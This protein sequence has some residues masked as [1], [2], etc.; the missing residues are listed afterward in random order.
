MAISA[1][2]VW[3]CRASG[4]GVSDNNG[5]GYAPITVST[6][7]GTDLVVDASLNTK[8]TSAT[9]NFVL[10]DAGTRIYV[11][12]GTGW[13]PGFYTILST[14]SNAA[15][16]NA[17]PAPTSTT[18]GTW[19]EVGAD[20][21]QQGAPQVSIDDVTPGPVTVSITANVIT[22]TGYTPTNADVG[23]LVHILQGTNCTA[24]WYQITATGAT[25]WTVTGAVNLP[26]SGTTDTS[27]GT[28]P[29]GNMGGALLTQNTLATAMVASNTAWVAGAFTTAAVITFAQTTGG[30]PTSV[31]PYTKVRGYGSVRGDSGHATLQC[32]TNVL[33]N[34]ISATG[35]G[36]LISQVDVDANALGQCGIRTAAAYCVV[37]GCK[38][39]N[40]TTAGGII[41]GG[42]QGLVEK[43]ELTGTTSNSGH[44]IQT[45]N[46]TRIVNNFIHDYDSGTSGGVVAI[47]VGG[48]SLN[49]VVEHNVIANAGL[50]NGPGSGEDGIQ[51]AS[52]GSIVRFNTIYNMTQ[53]GIN[54]TVDSQNM[55]I[56][57]NLIAN[58]ATG[59]LKAT[60]A[61]PASYEWD[62]NAYYHN[63][64]GGTVN[65]TSV[66]SVAGIYG[67]NPY[68]NVHDVI[69][70][71]SPFINA[72]TGPTANFALNNTVGGGNAC[73]GTA[74]FNSWPGNTGTTGQLDFG[75]VQSR[76]NKRV[77]IIH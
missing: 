24:G 4:T 5:G 8:V 16:L 1:N 27:S 53:Y 15:T 42:A 12:A 57:D 74:V 20:Y 51:L 32:L 70:S 64:A 28:K 25:T 2:T 39:Q 7:S 17:S 43:C 61:I 19:A 10:A 11:T 30:L 54:V 71:V 69:L 50:G 37:S 34:V 38:V 56:Q 46:T 49:C 63:G 47:K 48:S 45:G 21:S 18:G 23:N 55:V 60:A 44:C 40:W 35:Q 75:A 67:V 33:A 6:F 59:G 62:G 72:T 65:R 68:I 66:D 73:R 29:T 26:T 36:F 3:E 77:E 76:S 41:A 22:F 52:A 58:C 14:G 13:T 9:H 31:L